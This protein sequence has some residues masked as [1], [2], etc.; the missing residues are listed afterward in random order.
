M[1]RVVLV[2]PPWYRL[3]N[4]HSNEMPL[5]LC[6]LA[7]YLNSRGH[8]ARVLNQDFVPQAPS[9]EF[10]QKR[11]FEAYPQYQRLMS[12]PD[13]A[14][15]REAVEEIER[16]E[17]EVLG[18]TVQVGSFGSAR[19]VASLFKQRHPDVPV[20]VGGALAAIDP[21]GVLK[22]DAF[23]YCVQGE[24]EGA[25]AELVE[26]LGKHADVSDVANLALRTASGLRVNERRP[27][28]QDLDGLPFPD[29]DALV[30]LDRYP[31]D[32]LGA[33]LT[34]RGCPFRCTYCA[35]SGV[36]GHGVRFR[37]P[38]NVIAEM[39]LVLKRYGTRCFTFKD[40]TFT[41]KRERIAEL[42][43]MIRREL[44]E[45]NWSCKT[46]A[47]C[48]DEKIIA[49]MADAGCIHVE[50]GLES[51]C[52]EVL[53]AVRK[54]ETVEQIL[55]AGKLFR[56]AGIPTLVNIIVGFPDETPDQ[57]R[58]SFAV[59]R[60][61]KPG[62]ILASLLSPYP[63][64]DIHRQLVE[65]C[66]LD[67]ETPWEAYFHAS[68]ESRRLK[69]DPEF[70]AAVQEVFDAVEHYNRARWRRMRSFGYLAVRHPKTAVARLRK[71]VR[72]GR[73]AAGRDGS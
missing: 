47:D 29:R 55:R 7:G 15:W 40:D 61:M 27:Y 42:C 39:L 33:L 65:S 41:I 25:F 66:R 43:E 9:G 8:D 50:I 16:L 20:V 3:M 5:G 44:P 26:R 1:S 24:G 32:G 28:I 56:K 36:W 2:T 48:V 4:W 38:A 62:R 17:P 10:E 6:A 13:A 72:R 34:A 19:R 37:S 54:G 30:G 21:Q 11:M 60:S 45:V 12:D 64:T 18:M 23:D 73:P 14:I 63:G 68:A 69:T 70:A 22:F 57:M 52:P 53:Q 51:G 31:S 35:A 49:Q 67:P 59:A 71:Y 46:R 58:Q